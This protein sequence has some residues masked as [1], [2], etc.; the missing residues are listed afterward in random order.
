MTLALAS[1]LAESAARHPERTA[2]I[3]G[4]ARIVYRDLWEQTRR[5]GAVLAGM[6]IGP[7]DRVA[8]MLP[9][10]PDFARVYYGILA[11]GGVV[12]PVHALLT[13]EEVAYVLRDSGAK[14]LVCAGP[15]LAAGAPGAR[16]AEIP[17]LT[18]LAPPATDTQALDE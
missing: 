10:V 12:V 13:A 4:P 18:L 2:L 1:I 16:A 8:M 7:G 9:N 3:D 6:G 15:L 17:C 11:I 5:Y 14:L